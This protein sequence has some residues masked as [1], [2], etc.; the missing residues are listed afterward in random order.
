MS[1]ETRIGTEVGGYRLESVIGR[2]GMSV[3]YLAEQL[4]LG[5]KVAFKLLA[6]ELARDERFRERFLRESR[7]ASTIEH[8]NIIQIHDA[9]ETDGLLYI[10]M[11]F[12]E[13]PSLKELIARRGSLGLGR[14]IYI[15]EQIASALDL[16]HAKGLVHRD[17]KPANILLDEA[18]DHA[19][20][21]DF[22]IAKQTTA[23]GLTSTAMFI[24]TMEYCS[25]E[26]IEGQPVDARTDVYGLGCVVVESL[27]GSPPFV[28]ETDVALMHAHL[29]TPPPALTSRLR[30][31]PLGLNAVVARAL[32][33]DPDARYQTAGELAAALREGAVHR[34]V[35]AVARAAVSDAEDPVPSVLDT[36]QEPEAVSASL[37]SGAQE[38]GTPP[39]PLT[40]AAAGGR[41]R[42]NLT[43]PI[44]VAA[45]LLVGIV[46]AAA[47]ILLTRSG[48]SSPGASPS[49]TAGASTQSAMQ[50][51]ST[52][53]GMSMTTTGK[54]TPEQR[55]AAFV[56]GEE[57]WTCSSA[58]LVRGAMKTL[59]CSTLV[60][61]HLKISVFDSKQM[62]H[63]A[64]VA[65]RGSQGGPPRGTGRCSS[66]SWRGEGVWLH[67]EGEPGGRYFCYLNSKND[68]SHLVWT[69]TVG[70][71]TLY[72]ATHLSPNHRSLFYWWINVRH[73][74]F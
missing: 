29:S 16:A 59:A 52:D 60:P 40:A 13:G 4:R 46:G 23:R 41:P 43:V 53:T 61:E 66:T 48:S 69:S 65:A 3:I 6:P 54:G 50:A 74:L 22:G 70:V 47:G 42:R 34:G 45:T 51:G 8:P 36:T 58:R 11:R 32:A 33:K 56:T 10:A 24:G 9:G 55:L 67:G 5:R 71:P 20:L 28:H 44:A 57:A 27:T 7:L 26:Q 14:V 39:P 63:A 38:S 21:A 25:P 15:V 72:D 49:A 37:P 73:E 1:S 64:Y 12:V 62:L 17:V 35:P 31:L 2:G 30:E 68:T 18:S 19:F